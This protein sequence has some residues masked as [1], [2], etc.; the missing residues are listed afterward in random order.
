MADQNSKSTTLRFS[1]HGLVTKKDASQLGEGEYSGLSNVDSLQENS[2]NSRAGRMAFVATVTGAGSTHTLA[3]L[4]VGNADASNPRYVGDSCAIYRTVDKFSTLSSVATGV[5]PDNVTD[6]TERWQMAPYLAGTTGRPSAYFACRSKM[7][8]DDGLTPLT[9]LRNWGILPAFGVATAQASGFNI[10]QAVYTAAG[11]PGL[12]DLAAGGAF[13]GIA[14]ETV[15]IQVT[16]AWSAPAWSGAITYGAGGGTVVFYAYPTG[17]FYAGYGTGGFFTSNAVGGNTGQAPVTLSGT[18]YVLSST[19][20]SLDYAGPLPDTWEYSVNGAGFLSGGYISTT[21]TAVPGA[22]GI[23][24]QWLALNGHTAGDQWLISIT[25]SGVS[26]AGLLDGGAANSPGNA[27]AYS[28]CFAY[29]NAVTNAA[30]N[31]SQYMLDSSAVTNG[32]PVQVHLGKVTVTVWGTADPQITLINIYRIGGILYDAYR[33]VG[34]V[35]NPGVTAGV[36]NSTTFVDNTSDADLEPAALLETDNDPP[37]PSTL[38]TPY[39]TTLYGAPASTGFQTVTLVAAV[40]AGIGPGCLLYFTAQNNQETTEIVAVTGPA[41]VKVYLQLAHLTGETVECD[42]IVNAPGNLCAAAFDSTWVAGVPGSPQLLAKSKTG[43]PESF[44]VADASGNVLQINVGS[45]ANPIMAITPFRSSMV[46]L[47]LEKIYEIPV[48]SGVMYGPN[49]MANIGLVAKG[50]WCFSPTVLYFLSYDGIYAWAGGNAQ[51]ISEPID[52]TFNG[53]TLNGIAPLDRTLYGYCSMTYLDNEVRLYFTDTNGARQVLRYQ[54]IYN[55][56]LPAQ[57]AYAVTAAESEPDVG[58]MIVAVTTGTA[59]TRGFSLSDQGTSD[60]YPAADTT[61]TTGAAIAC[62]VKT[63][64]MGSP[65]MDQLFQGLLL[66]CEP[67]AQITVS[68]SYNYNTAVVDTMTV[69]LTAGRI[70]YPLLPNLSGGASGGREVFTIMLTFSWSA[71]VAVTLHAL[72]MRTVPLAQAEGGEITD[73]QDLQW[74]GDK[75]LKSVQLEFSTTNETNPVVLNV[76][77]LN[78]SAVELA[79]TT[80]TLPAGVTR[81]KM[82]FPIVGSI[83]CGMVRLRP[84]APTG[85]VYRI[86]NWEFSFDKEPTPITSFEAF[87]ITMGAVGWKFLFQNWLM[88]ICD[89]AVS[90]VLTSDTGT[91]TAS[92]LAHATWGAERY[93]LPSVWGAGLN[94]SKIYSIRIY[95]TGVLKILPEMSGFE[96]GVCGADRHTAFMQVPLSQISTQEQP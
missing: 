24:V 89:S 17:N 59:N 56:W 51:K 49:E 22:N 16:S 42:T 75:R 21:P 30:G 57:S 92:L 3:K 71:T 36:P 95:S 13:T 54:T 8:A 83:T 85:A 73:W 35:A 70:R 4:R 7:L 27:E 45:P 53:K 44:P 38:T 79:A 34:S 63:G 9:P 18:S 47:N 48:L 32:A 11:S 28:Y 33:L 19:Y 46:C 87:N 90:V 61:G 31:P 74:P 93:Y 62:S 77:I 25:G 5:S 6:A 50:A 78:G 29:V 14:A 58:Q 91:Y 52:G 72:I 26:F 15:L 55:R 81:G 67:G 82:A 64:W 76:D 20:W 69:P 12:N 43:Y 23:T 80:I 1:N 68:A 66:D 10:S 94:K 37:V 60:D 88:Y 84:A 2:T 86:H 41:T 40:A 65:D 39:K 96:V